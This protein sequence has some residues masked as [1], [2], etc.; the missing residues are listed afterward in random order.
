MVLDTTC[1]TVVTFGP[2]SSLHCILVSCLCVTS[3]VV[4]CVASLYSFLVSSLV[5]GLFVRRILV[6]C[7][8][9]MACLLSCRMPCPCAVFSNRLSSCCLR[10]PHVKC[11]CGFVAL[12]RFV[13]P[14]V[15]AHI[16]L[17]R[18][19]CHVMFRRV[20]AC[21]FWKPRLAQVVVIEEAGAL[22]S[23]AQAGFGSCPMLQGGVV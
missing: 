17:C 5:C 16:K 3:L 22:S 15:P 14:H 21:S 4:A 2:S 20:V 9:V 7:L 18:T 11:A 19:E 13:P 1:T 10:C 12:V 6:S 8:C 23:D